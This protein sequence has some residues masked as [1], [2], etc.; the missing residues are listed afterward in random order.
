MASDTATMDRLLACSDMYYA[1]DKL[2]SFPTE[3]LG[4]SRCGR[5]MKIMVATETQRH[6]LIHLIR[7]ET[8][9]SAEQ[10]G[11]AFLITVG[12]VTLE[13]L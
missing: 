7:A 4:A 6:E 9:L 2:T 12:T 3:S 11:A 8:K 5:Y 10:I 13:F 1:S